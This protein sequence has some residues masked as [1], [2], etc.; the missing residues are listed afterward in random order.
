MGGEGETA[1][2]GVCVDDEC[3]HEKKSRVLGLSLPTRACGPGSF[4]VCVVVL[5]SVC[6]FVS[7]EGEG[8]V[9]GEGWN[10]GRSYCWDYMVFDDTGS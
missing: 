3:E 5:L 8:K 7:D 2:S 4:C 10:E 6:V 1:L 9:E